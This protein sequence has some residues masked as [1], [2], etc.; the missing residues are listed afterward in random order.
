MVLC[1]LA[2]HHNVH[3]LQRAFVGSSIRRNVDSLAGPFTATSTR[4]LVHSYFTEPSDKNKKKARTGQARDREGVRQ[5]A[6]S[7]ISELTRCLLHLNISLGSNT[8]EI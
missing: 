2:I 6:I 7:Q 3:S 8:V 5:L 4:W 1:Q